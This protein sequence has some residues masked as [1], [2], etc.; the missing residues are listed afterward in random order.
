[1]PALISTLLGS[2]P[3]LNCEES[4]RL[5]FFLG[6]RDSLMY[7]LKRLY[8]TNCGF[9]ALDQT[10]ESILPR[11]GPT[12]LS[13]RDRGYPYDY[14]YYHIPGLFVVVSCCVTLPGDR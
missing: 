6:L 7:V 12:Y 5:L 2:D 4:A 13:H 9:Q 10:V 11:E 8:V 1:M 3:Q 14:Y